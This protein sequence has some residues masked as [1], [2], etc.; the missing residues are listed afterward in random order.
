[1][2]VV[3]RKSASTPRMRQFRFTPAIHHPMILLLRRWFAF[4]LLALSSLGVPLAHAQLSIEIVG[5][6]GAQIPIAIVPFGN[7]GTC[8]PKRYRA[9]CGARAMPMQS[10]SAR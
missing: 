5:G 7:E 1:L 10:S 8:A 3:A 6:A 2:R 9:R 4:G